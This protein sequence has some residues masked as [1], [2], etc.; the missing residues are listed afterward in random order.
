MVE[1]WIF[2]GEYEFLDFKLFF[3]LVGWLCLFCFFGEIEVLLFLLLFVCLFSFFLGFNCVLIELLFMLLMDL[4]IFDL[5]FLIDD[6]VIIIFD[7]FFLNLIIW[8][9]FEWEGYCLF[10][11]SLLLFFRKFWYFVFKVEFSFFEIGLVCDII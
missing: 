9:L 7:E 11:M 6:F 1:K 8:D 10:W 3:L 5:C 2:L 4:I